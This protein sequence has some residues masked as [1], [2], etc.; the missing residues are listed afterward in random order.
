MA[1]MER[2]YLKL[3]EALSRAGAA[4]S[5]EED[6]GPDVAVETEPVLDMS[7]VKNDAK[8]AELQDKFLT[9]AGGIYGQ[10]EEQWAEMMPDSP[11]R[12]RPLQEMNRRLIIPRLR[13]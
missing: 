8:F 2:D 10:V 6:M 9:E 7:V 13:A 3:Q 11:G 5:D 1:K 4:S 12:A